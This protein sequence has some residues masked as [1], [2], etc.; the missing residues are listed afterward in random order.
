M[1]FNNIRYNNS[2]TPGGNVLLFS[3]LHTSGE[4]LAQLTGIA[5]ILN[6]PLFELEDEVEREREQL[7]KE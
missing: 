2:P 1:L 4:Q 6:F 3:S 7:E 5:A